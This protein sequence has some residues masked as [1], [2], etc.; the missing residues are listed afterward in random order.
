MNTACCPR[1]DSSNLAIALFLSCTPSFG[2][3]SD[4][5]WLFFNITTQLW[6]SLS[7]PPRFP[8]FL[9]LISF[10]PNPCPVSLFLDFCKPIHHSRFYRLFAF[11]YTAPGDGIPLLLTVY[12]PS[13]HSFLTAR[14]SFTF[15]SYLGCALQRVTLRVSNFSLFT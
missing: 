10:Y 13:H 5:P 4:A 11:S 7:F 3:Y 9:L 8:S 15:F 12:V 6:N 1:D 2:Q 14:Q